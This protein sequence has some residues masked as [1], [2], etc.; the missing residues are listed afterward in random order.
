MSE[1]IQEEGFTPSDLT[2]DSI[3]TQDLDNKELNDKTIIKVVGVGGGG[4]NAINR[5]VEEG[6]QNVEFVAINT[7]ARDLLRN[8]ATVKISLSDETSRG[9]GAGA[10]P[11]KGRQ[12]AL[13]HESDIRQA[14]QGADMVFVTCGEGGGTG[15]GASPVVARA[16]RSQG[17]LTVGVVTRP[18]KFEGER[19]AESADRGI[20][21]LRKEVDALIVIPNDRLSSL[22]D[23]NITILNAFKAADGALLSGIQSVTELINSNAYI[24]VDF[25]D[26]TTILKD[27]GTALFGIGQS[28]GSDRAIHASEIAVTS[29]L[30]EASIDGAHG[31]LINIAGSEDMQL[32]EVYEAVDLVRKKAS[33]E[34]QIIWGLTFDPDMGD[35]IRVSVIAAGFDSETPQ[36]DADQPLIAGEKPSSA[37][38]AQPDSAISSPEVPS[39]KPI[40]LGG[41]ENSAASSS[42]STS[43]ASAQQAG[44]QSAPSSVQM[45]AQHTE[46]AA[47]TTGDIDI[48]P[49][50]R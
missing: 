2:D 4:G 46:P 33:P 23:K 41:D 31:I 25:N 10:D 5:M 21:A 34:A 37:A 13:N 44:Y 49:F 3:S 39:I 15:T 24:H 27:S 29:P 50:L 19:R 47:D 40:Q 42:T 28:K 20:E 1:D 17:A 43:S 6:W 32:P 38:T 26:V 35:V 48:P 8:E 22:A 12:A 45:P 11:E 9:L 18:F 16:A 14:L 36:E 7:D 30:L